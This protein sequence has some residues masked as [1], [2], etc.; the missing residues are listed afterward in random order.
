[1]T[2]II[3]ETGVDWESD[4][5]ENATRPAEPF[6]ISCQYTAHPSD[7]SARIMP[8]QINAFASEMLNL[9]GCF[10][11]AGTW[12]CDATNNLC[13][14]WT[15]YRTETGPGTLAGDVA[16]VICAATS[17][18]E[19]AEGT[20]FLFCQGGELVTG[21]LPAPVVP[22]ESLSHG[23]RGTYGIQPPNFTLDNTSVPPYSIET[24][25]IPNTSGQPIWV[26]VSL[27]LECDMIIL[28]AGGSGNYSFS[29]FTN[30]DG[31]GGVIMDAH[32]RMRN[33]D[34]SGQPQMNT[35]TGAVRQFE[36]PPGGMDMHFG[37]EGGASPANSARVENISGKVEVYGVYAATFDTF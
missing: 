10:N 35:K 25:N 8:D 22:P 26:I 18:G 1:M 5:V 30:A 34:G 4:T 15:A 16:E 31:T 17:V 37:F 14:N 33:I 6:A 24:V 12:N 29:R 32:F 28:D 19:V 36:I 23:I 11:P 27:V 13:L 20:E 2:G 21:S 3:P 9:A 7:C